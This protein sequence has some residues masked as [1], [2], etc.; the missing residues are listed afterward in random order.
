MVLTH[1]EIEIDAPP[2]RVREVVSR[3]QSALF[4]DCNEYGTSLWTGKNIPNGNLDLWNLSNPLNRKARLKLAISWTSSWLEWRSRQLFWFVRFLLR[5]MVFFLITI[6]SGKHR[7]GVRMERKPAFH[8]YWRPCLSLGAEQNE[9]RW[10]D[11]CQWR[12]FF[13][14]HELSHAPH[15]WIRTEQELRVI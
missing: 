2:E 10:N 15:V 5:P 8:F 3:I 13:W 4:L 11:I 9:P 12:E 7:T 1:T 6:A 14:S